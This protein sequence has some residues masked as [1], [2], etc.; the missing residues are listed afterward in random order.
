VT[1]EAV[2]KGDT[3]ELSRIWIEAQGSNGRRQLRERGQWLTTRPPA[4]AVLAN[5]KA[6]YAEMAADFAINGDPPRVHFCAGE[7]WERG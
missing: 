1:A 3:T 2:D 7:V 6:D 5:I 4:H